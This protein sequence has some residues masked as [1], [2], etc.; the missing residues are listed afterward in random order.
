MHLFSPK[1][2][3]ASLNTFGS[4]NPGLVERERRCGHRLFLP[5]V[6]RYNHLLPG[7]GCPS[8]IFVAAGPQKT[9]PG[10][11]LFT[12]TYWTPTLLRALS[13]ACVLFCK[14]MP[15]SL[16]NTLQAASLGQRPPPGPEPRPAL[17]AACRLVPPRERL[18]RATLPSL[19]AGG[20]GSR[21]KGKLQGEKGPNPEIT[22]M[23][24]PCAHAQ[25]P[26]DKLAATTRPWSSSPL[27]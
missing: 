10:S 8:L 9:R 5:N 1:R 6:N 12:N 21:E 25:C 20:G 18:R 23:W 27:R 13:A 19:R 14:G 16:M 15:I 22:R 7:A 17:R 24:S 11:S 3:L 4:S 26:F 2:D